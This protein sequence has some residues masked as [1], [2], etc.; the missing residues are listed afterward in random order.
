[1]PREEVEREKS[2]Y[3]LQIVPYSFAGLFHNWKKKAVILLTQVKEENSPRRFFFGSEAPHDVSD[4]DRKL[5]Y[6]HEN[7]ASALGGGL[8]GYYNRSLLSLSS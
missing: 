8:S 1:M 2:Q 7:S 3:F 4:I 6:I 5:N